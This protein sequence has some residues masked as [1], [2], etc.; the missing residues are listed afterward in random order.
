[1][2]SVTPPCS[3]SPSPAGRQRE[4]FSDRVDRTR[5]FDSSDR[6]ITPGWS[7][8]RSLSRNAYEKRRKA[9]SKMSPRVKSLWPNPPSFDRIAFA[10]RL[11]ENR[12]A[13][14]PPGD[15]PGQYRIRCRAVRSLRSGLFGNNRE[16]RALFAYFGAEP[17]EFLCSADC[18]AERSGFEPS[19]QV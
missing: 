13:H 9:V 19:V 14:V 15:K 4:R 3:F 12:T 18:V 1:L 5:H 11:T 16:R 10:E 8:N 6:S 2:P 7:A 17:A